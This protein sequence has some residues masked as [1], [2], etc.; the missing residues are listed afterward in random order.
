MAHEGA[1]WASDLLLAHP[2]TAYAV[3]GMSQYFEHIVRFANSVFQTKM[4][5]FSR[6][7]TLS[8]ED[9][10]STWHRSSFTVPW[11]PVPRPAASTTPKWVTIIIKVFDNQPGSWLSRVVYEACFTAIDMPFSNLTGL[12]MCLVGAAPFA[13]ARQFLVPAELSPLMLQQ[14]KIHYTHIQSILAAAEKTEIITWL[15]WIPN[16]AREHLLRNEAVHA[17]ALVCL[18]LSRSRELVWKEAWAFR[19]LHLVVPHT[20]A[21]EVQTAYETPPP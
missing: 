14:V 13:L 11:P 15:N 20:I 5:V 6:R 17:S 18:D 3:Q 4:D 16:R 1:F 21:C 2:I 10:I 7:L 8:M 19:D 9:R 12:D